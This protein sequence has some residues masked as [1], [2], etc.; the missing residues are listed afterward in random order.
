MHEYVNKIICILSYDKTNRTLYGL[1]FGTK[2]FSLGY[3]AAYVML[4]N[5]EVRPHFSLI[6]NV[7]FSTLAHL[8]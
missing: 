7:D 2:F 4:V 5:V 1:S 6:S 3:L 8:E